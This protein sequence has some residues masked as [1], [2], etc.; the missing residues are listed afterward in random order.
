MKVIIKWRVGVEGRWSD[1]RIE[2]FQIDTVGA[3][4][5]LRHKSY[6]MSIYEIVFARILRT[7]QVK[8]AEPEMHAGQ[9]LRF[10]FVSVE[11]CHGEWR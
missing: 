4:D 9:V 11:F 6:R 2:E 5:D 8:R 3:C 7:L 1:T 10:E